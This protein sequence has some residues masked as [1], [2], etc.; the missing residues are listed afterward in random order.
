M[1]KPATPRQ[2]KPPPAPGRYILCIGKWASLAKL[3]EQ[4]GFPLV[5][6][7]EPQPKP[8]A[9]QARRKPATK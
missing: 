1:T 3:A 6:P 5:E 4:Y 7:P 8:T 2:Q 9:R